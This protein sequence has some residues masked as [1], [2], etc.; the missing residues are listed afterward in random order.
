[1]I[2]A[3]L[4]STNVVVSILVSVYRYQQ[5]VDTPTVHYY[6]ILHTHL[7]AT[8]DNTKPKMKSLGAHVFFHEKILGFHNNYLYPCVFPLKYLGTFIEIMIKALSALVF[9]PK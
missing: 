4:L 6:C 3:N 1:M 2:M 5:R 9:I 8:C 7:Q